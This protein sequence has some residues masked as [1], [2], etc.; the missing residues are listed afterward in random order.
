[1][2]LKEILDKVHRLLGDDASTDVK[3]AMA[4]AM[5]QASVME[6][7]LAALNEENKKRRHTNNDLSEKLR[8][9]TE[10]REK[11]EQ[12][13]NSDEVA[14]WKSKAESYDKLID[15]KNKSILT[16]WGE[17]HTKLKSIQ[18][19]DKRYDTIKKVSDRLKVAADGAEMSVE[20]AKYNLELY[21]VLEVTGVL[22]EPEASSSGQQKSAPGGDTPMTGAQAALRKMKRNK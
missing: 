7:S 3:D 22:D 10:K 21:E 6:S 9:E 12:A 11:L 15:E 2:T 16:K 4:K 20:D 14:T 5:A 17:A 8:D 18:E 13:A 1:M 19:T